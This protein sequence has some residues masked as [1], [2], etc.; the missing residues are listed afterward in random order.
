[1]ITIDGSQGEGGGQILRTGIALAAVTGQAVRFVKIRAGRAKPGLRRQHLV[2]VQ[3]A[4]RISAA[5][6]TGDALDSRELTFSPQAISGGDWVFDIGTAGSTTLVLQTV[7]PLLLQAETAS[8]LRISGGTHNGMAPPAEFVQESLLP[9]LQG[10]GIDCQLTLERYGFFP[11]GGGQLLA[12]IQPWT[13]V[14][15]LELLQRGRQLQRQ[16]TA[17]IA[18]LPAHVARR[19]AQTL[20]HRLH[21][22]HREVDEVEVAADGPGNILIAR[23]RHQAVSSVFSAVGE[24]R[25]PAERVAEEVVK[26]VRRHQQSDAPVEEHLA[27]QLL[28]PLA[29]GAGGRF[30]C[31]TPSR[32]CR[33]NADVIG[34]FLGPVV[35]FLPQEDGTTLVVV[36][37]RDV[38]ATDNA[39]A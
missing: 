31:A 12:R 38:W 25:K 29:L 15:P 36:R 34:C 1:M 21:W 24:L 3:A 27:D 14:A 28:L 22:S 30:R 17:V 13:T 2:A 23:L 32:H 35:Q 5:A 19:E 39:S 33:T 10:I 18:D 4:A 8:T 9:V 26:Q 11:A 6:L 37:G 7:L 20:K 16:A